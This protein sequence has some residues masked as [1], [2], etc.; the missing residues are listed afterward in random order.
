[1]CT[2]VARLQAQRCSANSS[3]TPEKPQAQPSPHG[4][5]A[6]KEQQRVWLTWFDPEFLR[7][8]DHRSLVLEAAAP[9]SC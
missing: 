3:V 8:S 5:G 1:M 7:L 2:R 9:V 4:K 6:D